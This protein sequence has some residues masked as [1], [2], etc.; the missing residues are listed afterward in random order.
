MRNARPPVQA[1]AA[2]TCA[3][4]ATN[5]TVP[6]TLACP[7]RDGVTT[8]DGGGEKRLAPPRKRQGRDQRRQ[9]RLDEPDLAE[10]RVEHG[11]EHIPMEGL[12]QPETARCGSLEDDP[13]N[14]D[15]DQPAREDGDE[16]EQPLSHVS[17]SGAEDDY[18]R[19]RAA[20]HEQQER[21][22]EEASSGEERGHAP[23]R[24]SS[25]HLG[26]DPFRTGAGC[27]DMEHEGTRDRM[28][29]CRDRPPGHRVGASGQALVERSRD[30][31]VV[32]THHVSRVDP[33]SR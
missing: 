20:G 8:R 30:G 24:S 16:P 13:G 10:A 31:P 1:A 18:E 14:R 28:S 26:S 3:T 11:R 2:A 6:L 29:V 12:T 4:S 25:E 5:A 22:V 21:E 32:W 33:A 27:L 17:R 9:T 19:G 15:D 7:A 23:R